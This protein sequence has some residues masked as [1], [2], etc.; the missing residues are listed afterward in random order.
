MRLPPANDKFVGMADYVTESFY[1]LL[2][3]DSEGI[4]DS[5]SSRGSHHTSRECFMALTVR[6]PTRGTS[7]TFA[8]GK[9]PLHLTPIMKSRQVG[10]SRLTHG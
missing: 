10:G 3:G 1:D 9:L 6:K 5:D 4:S 8:R 7:P 2:V